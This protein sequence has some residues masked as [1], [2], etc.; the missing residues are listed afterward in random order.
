MQ[1]K[2]TIL[3][4]W[5]VSMTLLGYAGVRSTQALAQRGA[6]AAQGESRAPRAEIPPQD[7]K[8][9]LG[10]QGYMGFVVG[11]VESGST[12]EEAGIRPGDIITHASTGHKSIQ[13]KTYNAYGGTLPGSRFRFR[14][15]GS[16]Q[17]AKL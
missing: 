6:S 7:R 8:A 12:A 5:V 13:C 16:G 2:K 11:V 9:K 14:F 10:V 17:M 1:M 15:S 4:L 3:M